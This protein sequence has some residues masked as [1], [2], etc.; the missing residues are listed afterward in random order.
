MT[1]IGEI[2]IREIFESIQAPSFL[3]ARVDN[4]VGRI[5]GIEPKIALIG[6]RVW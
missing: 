1:T 5:E 3:K 2:L 4:G 6:K